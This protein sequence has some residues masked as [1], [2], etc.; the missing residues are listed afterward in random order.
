[1]LKSAM[2]ISL[3]FSFLVCVVESTTSDDFS[4]LVARSRYTRPNLLQSLV[5][6]AFSPLLDLSSPSRLKALIARVANTSDTF[7]LVPLPLSTISPTVLRMF[8]MYKVF[9]GLLYGTS[10]GVR[11]GTSV[12]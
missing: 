4:L 9:Q 7:A 12:F 1:M 11:R 2:R 10:A 3:Y 8:G 6:I 5:W